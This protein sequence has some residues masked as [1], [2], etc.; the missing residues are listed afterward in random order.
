MAESAHLGYVQARLQALYGSRPTDDDWRLLE[1]SVDL[2]HY[3]DAVRSTALKP[4]VRG[5]SP[6][7][8]AIEIERTLRANWRDAVKRLAGWAPS[9]WHQAIL[10]CQ[11]LPELPTL[12][13]LIDG[14]SAQPWMRADPVASRYAIDDSVAG[15]FGA[16]ESTE[17]APMVASL[18]DAAG[19]QDAWRRVLAGRV[20]SGISTAT[21]KGFSA[22]EALLDAHIGAMRATDPERDGQLLRAGLRAQLGSAFRRASGTMVALFAYLGLQALD[23]ERV[24]AGLVTRRLLK[25]V[26]EGMAWA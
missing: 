24:R 7:S 26:P 15:V 8:S 19:V 16:L 4:W 14:A 18:R 3:L 20:P 22:L 25:R 6:D 2:Q 17:L 12:A 5:I 9:E 13:H 1:S 23:G 11:W 10:W 21:R